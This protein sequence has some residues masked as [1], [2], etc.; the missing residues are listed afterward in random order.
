M[1]RLCYILFS[2]LV[3]FQ[4]KGQQ[5]SLVVI[6]EK[7]N[8][9]ISYQ[10]A[11]SEHFSFYTL[12]QTTQAT[13]E[14][15]FR[16]N[17]PIQ[18]PVT[19]NIL[20]EERLLIR[21]YL[22]KESHDTIRIQNNQ[23]VFSGTNAVYNECLQKIQQIEEYCHSISYDRQHELETIDSLNEFKQKSNEKRA[24]LMTFL[25]KKN[26]SADFIHNQSY[27]IDC[28]FTNLYYNKILNLYNKKKITDEWLRETKEQLSFDF[29]HE[30]TLCYSQYERML[31]MNTTIN[32]FIIEKH[33]PQEIDKDKI[34]TFLFNE[35][36]KKITG[37]N[38]ENAWARL[39]YYD[40]FQKDFSKD[41]PALYDQFRSVY[42][43]SKFIDILSPEV[44]KVRQFHHTP[45]ATN[46]IIFLP[47]DST[48][49]NLEDA[50]HPFIGKVV[51]VDLWATWC[52]PCQEM[53][54]H[55]KAMKEKTKDMDIIYLYISIDR[56]ENREKWEKMV[57]YYNLEGYHLHAGTTL[58]KSFY[59]SLGNNGM[60]SIPQF[61]II[62]KDGKVAIEKAAAPDDLE[63]VIEQLKQV[64]HE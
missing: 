37:K 21:A 1:K 36:K 6:P 47:T 43:Q 2:L 10:L 19:L 5:A 7:E 27:I 38:L 58:A 28:I 46:H 13:P 40:I 12:Y 49:Q 60:L 51:Y 54:S 44:D 35:Y 8:K 32:Y 63:K 22:T 20:T 31:Y 24:D 23:A 25:K 9:E 50:V 53:F 3:V 61:I 56:P 34:N 18:S 59:T 45:E 33:S 14:G 62:G 55:G 29:Q 42:P 11:D 64:S 30:E 15:I 17:L 39:I 52:G 48:A 57:R 4:L 16:I 26:V 41:I